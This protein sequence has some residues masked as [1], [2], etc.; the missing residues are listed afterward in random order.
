M[1]SLI[2]LLKKVPID[3]GQGSVADYTEGKRIAKGLTPDGT[4][5]N[6]LDLGARHGAQTR[7]LREQGYTVTS[8]DIDPKFVGCDYLNANAPLPY[9]DATFDF[10]WCSEVI[11]H[12]ENPSF[13][14][15]ELIRVTKP[16]GRLILTTPNSYMWLFSLLN[17]VGL[18]PQ[19]LQRDD[20]LHFFDFEGVKALH[21]DATILG[22][23][24][25]AGL[26]WTVRSDWMLKWLT[27][28]FVIQID[29]PSTS[30]EHAE[31]QRG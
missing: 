5:R 1:K 27:P 15:A 6:A 4:N 2:N 14:L 20:H 24:P 30:D 17:L 13:S 31:R 8:G 3:L 11:E 16:G 19:K 12:L 23:F 28:T 9:G 25:Y 26:K 29:R 18:T 21:A 7:W 22:Y 10:V